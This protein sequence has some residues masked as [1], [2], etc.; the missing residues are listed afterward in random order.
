[1]D[2]ETK[3]QIKELQDKIE[4]LEQRPQPMPYPYYP[5]PYPYWHERPYYQPYPY[6]TWCTT[7]NGTGSTFNMNGDNT[8][9][10]S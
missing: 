4:R 7:T 5:P 9:N 6:Q 1:M 2:R 8:T 3:K 10:A